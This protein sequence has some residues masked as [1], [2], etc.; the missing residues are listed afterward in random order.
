MVCIC[1]EDDG[2]ACANYGDTL[3]LTI[4]DTDCPGLSAGQ[5]TLTKISDFVWTGTS[6]CS[7]GA[8]GEGEDTIPWVFTCHD[9]TEAGLEDGTLEWGEPTALSDSADCETLPPEVPESLFPFP[10][11]TSPIIDL[12]SRC[13]CPPGLDTEVMVEEA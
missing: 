12:G 2:C 6:S 1:C 10:L 5:V 7:T 8:C 9:N 11:V 3:L 13:C 4:V